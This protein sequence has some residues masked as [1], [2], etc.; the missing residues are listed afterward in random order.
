MA[1][2]KCSGNTQQ[3]TR[4]IFACSGAADVGELADRAARELSRLGAGRMFC[5]PGVGAKLQSFV[6]TT[7]G[8]DQILALDG[9]GVDCARHILESSEI[10]GFT[11][12]RVTD[13]GL[14]KGRT[15]VDEGSA[16]RVVDHALGLLAEQR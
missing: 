8:A 16:R 11:H 9:C 6:G 3:S 2:P 5:L 4:L 10:D 7:Q 15:P 12:V 13:L 14:E 1:D